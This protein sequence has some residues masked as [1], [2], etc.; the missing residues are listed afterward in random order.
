MSDNPFS[1]APSALGYLFQCRYAFLESLRRLR[2]SEEFSVSIE[3]L[4]DVVFEKDGVVSELLQT[5]HHL[6]RSADLTDASPDLWKTIRIWCERLLKGEIT[7]GS[8]FMLITTTQ[9]GEGSAAKYLKSGE[10][11]NV[12]RAIERLNATSESSTSQANTA[13]YTAFRCLTPSQKTEFAEAVVVVDSVA[14]ITDMDAELR[15]EIFFAVDQKFLV[16]Y[17]QRL[18]GW[19]LQRV[20][21]QLARGDSAPILSEELNAVIVD[22]REQFKQDNLPIDEDIMRASVDASGY[23]DNIFVHQLRLID[24]GNPRI[25]HAIRNYF[26][27]FEQRSRWIREQLLVVGELDSYEQRLIEECDILFQ[28]MRDEL[29]EEATEEAKKIAAQTLYKW[30]ET[31]IHPPI[32]ASVD[33]PSIARGTYQILSDNQRVGWHPEFVERLRKLLETQRA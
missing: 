30:V 1:A 17:L 9:A 21:K 22:L 28:Q 8:T 5:K 3:T 32:R 33:E 7:D 2:K 24:I 29:G 31:N 18:E 12:L 4:D 13:A 6:K 25:F 23:Q 16:S 14:G 20:I 26:R 15:E 19:W 11:R 10:S 27:A